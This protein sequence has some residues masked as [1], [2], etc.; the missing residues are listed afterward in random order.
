M[1]V[2]VDVYRGEDHVGYADV[3][4]RDEREDGDRL[5][6]GGVVCLVVGD[7]AGEGRSSRYGRHWEGGTRRPRE[8]RCAGEGSRVGT[9]RVK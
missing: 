7:D 1:R 4:L 8:A 5:A 3:G 6:I 2:V 9:R